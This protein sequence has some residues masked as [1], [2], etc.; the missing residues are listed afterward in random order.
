M[1]VWLKRIG[2]GVGT[3][4]AL[5]I[6]AVGCIY[7]LSARHFNRIYTVP[8]ETIAASDDSV[9][10]ARGEH[11]VTAIAGCADC[12]GQGL[13]GA[14][15]IDGPPMG[16]IVALNLTKGDGGIG[17]ILTPAL[18]ERAVR[19]GVSHDGHALRI[20]PAD[21]YQYMSDDDLR[22]VVAYVLH[23]PPVG[24]TLAPSQLMLLPRALL[25]AGAMP[26]LPAETIERNGAA[27]PMMVAPAP[28]PEYGKYL[29][30]VA[31][32]HGCHGPGLSGG[33]IA[34]GDPSWGPAANLTPSG[35]LGKWTEAEFK[36]TLRTGKRPDGSTLK[37]P[38]PWKVVG[39][40]TDDELH[41][42][43]SY[44]QSVPSRAY[45]TH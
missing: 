40:M 18:I 19:H 22:A 6:V 26:L 34:A 21:E 16:R 45:G 27:K 13:R 11:V 25:V 30:L 5:A 20:M 24:N 41:A 29:S 3:L 43:W 2:Y 36:Q 10:I 17:A 1:R 33:K 23:L 44:L 37:D 15:V 38:M 32:C 35:N 7:A 39:H 31:G 8:D 12:H 9:T 28:T 42:L 14:P 4:V